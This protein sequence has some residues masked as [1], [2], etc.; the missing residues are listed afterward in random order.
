MDIV[1]AE[2]LTSD[3]EELLRLAQE[4]EEKRLSAM[5]TFASSVEQRFAQC[6]S[7]RTHKEAEWSEAMGMF[8]P[9]SPALSKSGRDLFSKDEASKKPKKFNIVRPKVRIAHSQLVSMQF[10]AGDKNWMLAQ[11]KRPDVD[12]SEAMQGMEKTIADQL[13][14]TNYGKESR[15]AMLD[16]IVLGTGVLKGPSN[17]GALKKIWERQQ[18]EMGRGVYV[19][20]FAEEYVPKVSRVDPWMFFPDHTVATREQAEWAIEVHPYSKKDL[21]K[22]KNHRKFFA[23]QIDEVLSEEPKDYWFSD[24]T[25]TTNTSNYD[26]FRNK[27]TVLEYNGVASSDC[28]C[29]I[30]PE[31]SDDSKDQFWVTAFV[32]NGKVIYFDIVELESVDSIPYA[33]GVWEKDPGSIFGFGIPITVTTQQSVVNGIYDVL[34]ENA[35]ISSG[36]LLVIDKNIIEPESST[37]YSIEPWKVY[38]ANGLGEDISRA[39][40]QFQPQSNQGDLAAILDMARGFADEESGVPLIQGGLEGVEMGSSATGTALAM[41]A[42]TSVLNLKSQEWDDQV[43]KPLITWAF[44]WNMLYNPDETIK[45]DFEVDVTTPTSMIRKNIEIQNLEKLSVELAQNPVLAAEIKPDVLA[46]ARLAG[47]MLPAD[48]F[49]KTAEEKQAEAEQQANQPDPAMIELQLKELEIQIAQEKVALEREKLQWESSRGQQRDAW[50]Y[51]ERMANSVARREE[52]QA[53]LLKAQLE[54]ETELIKMAA[55]Q[56]IAL[57]ELETR[58]GI[59]TMNDQTKQVLASMDLDLKA[60]GQ[61]TTELELEYAAKTGKGI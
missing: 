47:M 61:R 16:M 37:G 41:K 49:L 15:D 51:E 53:L 50:E 8:L 19:P 10:G 39:F 13:D 58:F 40:Y 35:K 36:P 1:V 52:N 25:D 48:N 23:D 21:A 17:C 31:L 14:R 55:Q 22:L 4:L 30:V 6:R 43:T 59:A 38:A 32:V 28:A 33:V 45:G 44:E 27:Y 29:S 12:N 11:S 57:A 24:I 46:R 3:E 60:R 9:D 5:E 56:E 20:K 2:S 42:S 18:D 26:I 54:K 34:V 7:K